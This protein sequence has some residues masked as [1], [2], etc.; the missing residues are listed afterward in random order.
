MGQPFQCPEGEAS[1]FLHEH[2]REAYA[3]PSRYGR[4]ASNQQS[5]LTVTGWYRPATKFIL[6]NL[7]CPRLAGSAKI[8]E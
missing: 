8:V 5:G 4:E 7:S 6:N 2:D 1:T 3:G